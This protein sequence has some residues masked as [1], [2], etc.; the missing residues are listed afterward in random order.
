VPRY[1][2]NLCSDEMETTDIVGET[3]PDDLAALTHALSTASTIVQ[4]RLLANDLPAEGWI[5]VEDER[6]QTV[7]TLPL[8]AAAY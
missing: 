1:Y 7:L 8:R 5:E 3:C 6:H 4:R 2:F